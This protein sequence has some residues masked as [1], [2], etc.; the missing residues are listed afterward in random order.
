MAD[1]KK[2]IALNEA[3]WRSMA[4]NTAK[5]SQI[6]KVATRLTAPA[7][8]ARYVAVQNRTGVPWWVIA[9]IHE[10]EASGSWSANLAQGDPWNRK[11]THVPA[12]RGPF[13][14]WEAAA[15]DALTNCAP[16]AAD[17][18][19]WSPGGTLTLLEEYNG[20]GYYNRGIPSPYLWAGTN[21][22][23]KGKYVA[24]GKFD[25]NA[26]DTQLGCAALIARMMVR[27]SSISLGPRPAPLP[28]TPAPP[29]DAKKTTGTAGVAAGSAVV[30]GAAGA[31]AAAKAGASPEV[32]TAILALTIVV[33]VVFW[34]VAR[35]IMQ[36]QG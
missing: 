13:T 36:S 31:A 19:D 22:Y 14:S 20:L 21:Q 23:A 25:P 6:D 2:L 26:V 5:V 1:I 10:R 9:V 18:A 28:P 35:K 16:H 32:F 4:I 24:D 30:A 15:I 29:P 3:R 33:A 17:W 7:A 11:S 8:K 12:G 27:D 34:F